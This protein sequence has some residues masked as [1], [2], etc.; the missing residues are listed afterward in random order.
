MLIGLHTSIQKGYANAIREGEQVGAE[1]IQ[2]FLRQNLSWQKRE[3]TDEEVAEFRSA[4]K[5]SPSVK[6]VIAHS[7][8]LINLASDNRSTVKR[9]IA[10]LKDELIISS[11]LGIEVYV[12]HPGSHRGAGVEAGIDKIIEGLKSVRERCKD[13]PVKIAF[14]TTA[15]SGN[16]IG[17]N[18]DEIAE[19]IKRS[20]GIIDPALCIDTAHLY[21]AG[22]DL[23]DDREYERLIEEIRDKIG[24]ERLYVC[25]LNDSKVP[26]ASRKDRH[27]HIGKGKIDLKVFKR[28]LHDARLSNAVG[29]LET[30][31]EEREDSVSYDLI[32]MEVLKR[33]RD[34]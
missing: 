9:S 23:N 18:I 32:N 5:N 6:K 33:L 1:V 13:L 7:S 12:M 21:G 22:Y 31:K 30:P 26:L 2:I 14:E 24:L 28:I 15:G 4:L 16:Q 19:I 10:L 27:H 29:I 11:R 25:H 3:V 8:Y 34:E 20:E 17:S